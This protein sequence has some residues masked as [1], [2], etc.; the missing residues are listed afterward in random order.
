VGQL[1]VSPRGLPALTSLRDLAHITWTL[2]LPPGPPALGPEPPCEATQH[3]K[4]WSECGLPVAACT[5]RG[6][7]LDPQG[8][9]YIGA[10]RHLT[11]L[12]LQ[13]CSGKIG[14]AWS[15]ADPYKCLR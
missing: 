15:P 12:Q 3:L 4:T 13:A 5:L 1:D 8:L 2:A 7:V 6:A 11:Q 9:G 10:C 14:D